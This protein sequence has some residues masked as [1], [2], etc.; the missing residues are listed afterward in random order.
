MVEKE[1]FH[2]VLDVFISA[3]VA[4]EQRNTIVLKELSNRTIHTASTAQD[5]D[6]I[7]IA[8]VMYSLSK[9]IE[10]SHYQK[11]PGWEK[12]QM[13]CDQSFER[14]IEAL[15]MHNHKKFFQ[16]VQNIQNSLKNISGDLQEYIDEVLMKAKVNKAS[17]IYE[18]GISLGKTAKLLG[19]S[20]WELS[21]YQ[22]QKGNSD[23]KQFLETKDVRKRI[24][25]TMDLFS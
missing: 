13:R 19:V 20:Q 23:T 4:F 3:K 16:E 22:G 18:H 17:K 14:A 2:N 25:E 7:M 5:S 12:F 6:S 15:R 24:Q 8:V 11:L 21:Q 1:E 9:L 10:R